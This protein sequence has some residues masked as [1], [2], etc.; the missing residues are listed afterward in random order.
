MGKLC[1]SVSGNVVPALFIAFELA[2]GA[3]F[4]QTQIQVGGLKI[5]PLFLMTVCWL[6]NTVQMNCVNESVY[7]IDLAAFSANVPVGTLLY[8]DTH[9]CAEARNVSHKLIGSLIFL[10]WR[11]LHIH[12][13][14]L[15]VHTN[16]TL[17]G[18][19][20]RQLLQ[21]HRIVYW[22]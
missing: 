4:S 6:Y 10:L 17:Y 2:F 12:Y 13:C 3:L 19:E 14:Y 9:M 8:V 15:L 21:Y 7:Y 22:N 5:R 16:F 20:A 11:N 18:Y 1:R